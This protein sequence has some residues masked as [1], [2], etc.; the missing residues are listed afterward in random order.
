MEA[1]ELVDAVPQK[2][3]KH[4]SYNQQLKEVHLPSVFNKLQYETEV[5]DN[6]SHFH[7]A[8]DDWRQLSMAPSFLKFAKKADPLSGSMALL[9]HHWQDI[10][11]LWGEAMDSSD[12]EGLRALLDLLQK[13]T[14]DLRTTIAPAYNDLL[15][16]LL[17]LLAKS[18]SPTALTS[19]LET[20][21]CLFRYLLV[22][23]IHLDLLEHTWTRIKATLPK[24]LPEIQR[25]MAEVWGSVLRKLKST[26]R[27]KAVT[28]LA[29]EAEVVD[30]ASAWVLVYA[31]K[32]VS[33]TLHTATP[34]I[35]SPIL[36][37]HLDAEDPEPTFKLLR[38]SLTAL[39]HHVKTAD[40]FADLGNLLIQQLKTVSQG[41]NV[42]HLKRTLAVV[43][44]ISSVRQGSR[45]TENQKTTLVSHLETL[46]ITSDLHPSL[47]PFVTSIYAATDMSHWIGPGLKFLQRSWGII[48]RREND[49]DDATCIQFSLKLHG[50]L[51]ELGWG[52]W[53]MV[54]LPLVLK[55]TV[56]PNLLESEPS[57]LLA[58]CASLRR[59]KKISPNEVDFVW[60][61]KIEKCALARLEVLK[62]QTGEAVDTEINDIFTLSPFFSEAVIPALI[63][64][65][66]FN[67]QKSADPATDTPRA[68]VIEGAV[69]ALSRRPAKEWT[70]KVPL[71]AWSKQ[72]IERWSWSHH[73]IGSMVVL[74]E[75]ITSNVEQ[76]PFDSAYP[77]LQSALLSYSRPLRLS[78]LRFL[79]SKLVNVPE[80]AGEV[81]KRCLQGEEATVDLQGVRERVL[82]IG[83][84]GQ[85]VGDRQGADVCARWL[86]AQLKVNLR[87]LWSPAIAAIGSLAQRFGDL[88]W[89]LLFAELRS[90]TSSDSSERKVS[91]GGVSDAEQMSDEDVDPWEEERSWRD[92]SAHKLRVVSAQWEDEAHGVKEYIKSHQ[93]KERFDAATYEFQLLSGLGECSSLVEKYNRE[94]IPYF[95]GLLTP[96]FDATTNANIQLSDIQISKQKLISW[97]TLFSKFANPKALYATST[98]K[99][100]YVLF[101]SHPYR[102]LQRI[103]L[104]CLLTY[105]SPHLTSHEDKFR[106]LLDD[107]RWRDELTTLE[108]V[109]LEHRER[110]EVV[111]VLTRLLFG[112]M[113]EKKGRTRGTDRRAA[114]LTALAN[115]TDEELGLLVDLM[116]QPLGM[117][118]NSHSSAAESGFE[119]GTFGGEV[120][121][122][123]MVGY[124]MLLGDLMRLLGSRLVN[125]WPAL[126]GSTIDLVNYAQSKIQELAPAGQQSAEEAPENEDEVEDE[127]V[128]EA[129]HVDSASS[130]TN[131]R[132]L[133][134]IRQ[135]GLKRFADFF[136]VP[137]SFPFDP[138][139]PSAF[140]SFISPRLAHLA[141]ENTQAPSALLDLFQV[142]SREHAQVF[143]LV[144]Y[145]NRLLPSLYNCLVATNVKPAVV[146]RVFD[147]VEK[148]LG[149][150]EEDPEVTTRVLEPHVDLLLTN[151][152]KLVEYAK[153]TAPPPKASS[154]PSVLSL[155][156]TTPLGQR[157]LT[158]LS[159]LA[160]YST[161]PS[162]AITLLNLFLPVFRKPNKQ[163]PE[164]VKS[165]ILIIIRNMMRLVPDLKSLESPLWRRVFDTL[166]H[167][168]LTLKTRV[169][170]TQLVEAFTQLGS[171]ANEQGQGWLLA[172]AQQLASLNAYSVKRLDEPDFD[173][174]LAA[175]SSFND[176]ASQSTSLA[177]LAWI[178][179]LQQAFFDIQDGEELAVRAAAAHTLRRFV[180]VVA[181]SA[182]IAEAIPGGSAEATTYNTVFLSVYLSG[183]R[184]LVSAP[185]HVHSP[186]LE[187]SLS[188]KADLLGVLSYT[189][190]QSPETIS[191]TIAALR[192]LL[193]GGDEEANFFN[194]VLHIQVHRRT[195]A[196]RRLG[197]RADREGFQTAGKEHEAGVVR[198]WLIPIVC[199]FIGNGGGFKT[200]NSAQKQDQQ[201]HLTTNEAIHAMGKLAR[202]LPWAPYYALVQR[203]L[204]LAKARTEWEK[205]YV[206]TIVSVLE[207]FTFVVSDGEEKVEA[208]AMDVDGQESPTAA[209][210]VAEGADA[211]AEEQEEAAVEEGELHIPEAKP[212]APVPRRQPKILTSL[213]S[214]LLPALLTY[215]SPP[216]HRFEEDQTPLTVRL[217]I[218]VAIARLTLYLPVS[219]PQDIDR[220]KTE[221]RR[222]ATELSHMMRSRS[223]EVR[224]S[225]REVLGRIAMLVLRVG[226]EEK[227]VPAAATGED[228]GFDRVQYL[229][230]VVEEL[231]TALVRGPQVHVLACTVQSIVTKVTL[232]VEEANRMEKN[233]EEGVDE[234][235]KTADDDSTIPID[236]TKRSPILLDNI[237]HLICDIASRILFGDVAVSEGQDGAPGPPNHASAA[238]REPRKS[239][240]A[241][242]TLFALAAQFTSP[243]RLPDLFKDVRSVMKTTSNMKVLNMVDEVLRRVSGGLE[244]N[245]GVEL[246]KQEADATTP[247]DGDWLLTVISGLITGNIAFLKERP[248]PLKAK[249]KKKR[250]D[251]SDKP[252]DHIVQTKRVVKQEVD[253][254]AHNS[255]RFIVLGLD[256]FNSAMRR[257]RFMSASDAAYRQIDLL[258]PAIGNTLYSASTPVLLAALKSVAL[259]VTRFATKLPGMRRALPVYV[260]QVISI[261]RTS[262][263]GGGSMGG[264][265]GDLLQSALRTLGVM[266]RDGPKTMTG[267]DGTVSPGVEIQEKDLSFL[268]ELVTPDLEDPDKQN[269]TFTLLRA[270]VSRRFIVPEMYDIMEDRVAPLLVQSQSGVV[271]EQARALLLQFMLDYP[272]G[273]GRLQKTLAFLLRNA[274]TYVHESGRV[275][276]LELLGAILS[277]FQVGLIKEYGEMVFVTLVMVI[278]NDDSAK[279]KEM[280]AALL[281]TLYGRFDP[282]ARKT[283][284]RSWLRKWVKAGTQTTEG[285]KKKL[286]W[287]ALQVWGIVVDAA[288]KD[289]EETVQ[290]WCKDTIED[291]TLALHQ[292]KSHFDSLAQS[293]D[294]D[295]MDVDGPSKPSNELEW[296][297]AYYSLTALSKVLRAVPSYARCDP[298]DKGKGIPVPWN[299]VTAHLLFPHAWVR[300]AAS[301]A[302]GV[303]FNAHPIASVAAILQSSTFEPG[304]PFAPGGLRDTASK[305]C[306]QLKSEHLD[307]ALGLQVVKNLVWI[308]RY[309]SSED[310]DS[311]QSAEIEVE[312]EAED[313]EAG[314]A[315]LEQGP[316]G[317]D[318]LPWLFSKLSYQV[319][320]ALIRR[321]GRQGRNNPNWTQQPLAVVRW[322]AAMV[323]YLEPKRL[324]Q[325][326]THILSPLYRI[327][328]EDTIRD[329]QL[330]ELKTTAIELRELVQQKVGG[331]TFSLVYNTI[332][333]RILDTRRD[334]RTKRVMLATHHP[335]QAQRRKE[336][337]LKLKKD[338]KKRRDHSFIDARGGK[339][340]RKE[341]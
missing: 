237:L 200:T 308:G 233:S 30:D 104:T 276:I 324:E 6:D 175:Y 151:L 181:S 185:L 74:S 105:K 270:I 87:P 118:R 42:Q 149:H 239:T 217:P 292:S 26:A 334:R 128:E 164:K 248:E 16:R 61:T 183:L 232:G 205:V 77:N 48:E 289:Q 216:S 135:L 134:T 92:P 319:R 273:K 197:E 267:S 145:D 191:P 231:A 193:E 121:D 238:F 207:N 235:S 291:V 59:L 18:I 124:L 125:Y 337:K 32:S 13:F 22:P 325:F 333:Q 28:L 53:K 119:F 262:G 27:V 328:E 317:L 107:T 288:V 222:L 14:H 215:L 313:D 58:F 259:L 220:K 98:L 326:L 8:L 170:R 299:L 312:S 88:V 40:Q 255:F 113:L 123:Q 36:A 240:N 280:A 19:L 95:L 21:N 146:D 330:E 12:D 5:A 316:A 144:Q 286:A 274:T 327:I 283:F 126:L 208:D 203:Y 41:T 187:S 226:E 298:S 304:H 35:F 338:S 263:G 249:N 310:D 1:E 150:A 46:P 188:V 256:L 83:R 224:D 116:L 271:R 279:C 132:T 23:S 341:A 108:L 44:V 129:A 269:V 120:G 111:D 236:T 241:S 243:S 335:E 115:C 7:Q 184:S 301:R 86:I 4:Q 75:S 55:A 206:R 69:Q 67:L 295:S 182:V 265:D 73:V 127:G 165:N 89:Q 160:P 209:A 65:I 230:V 257:G 180:D 71:Q 186:T 228:V 171:I 66:D 204:R 213:K 102:P 110:E 294:E 139:L 307:S 84:V 142:W 10:M 155:S 31:C 166:S 80:G 62:E 147:I 296:Q 109:N 97:F 177:P 212:D 332:R 189:V 154:G 33:Q 320:G 179:L 81:V 52:G 309:W 260:N 253:H 178:P 131:P 148:I 25:A 251:G 103:A 266:I 79:N 311:S 136:R 285:G 225:V 284:V 54:A 37:Y 176:D 210:E 297:L 202:H 282:D 218:A 90:V 223:Q 172:I 321:K 24:C 196:V 198:D 306:D 76:L 43:T 45:L 91:N 190:A 245:A 173:R 242:Y 211:E 130:S 114:V 221:L 244:R 64:L 11:A 163:A 329:D 159:L 167:L 72:A 261:I 281:T 302:L 192:P 161:S 195:R 94:L 331:T 264:T 290:D 339:R 2:R 275:S 15:D 29:A 85:V 277:K 50:S 323:T 63:G 47:L 247:P 272:Q 157:H 314:E 39:I 38:R 20:F 68:W 17:N 318:N 122:G 93:E 82:R 99:S 137:I 153:H 201:Q 51:A 340:R 252:D 322:F 117:D 100:V 9:L 219:S 143:F 78:A 162:Q 158:I 214:K 3:F 106:A 305:L 152:A 174:R 60:R 141:Q 156:L 254:Y 229:R 287:V 336:K 300:T 199:W 227:N 303:L 168:L 315:E 101:L 34:S 169:G 250:R 246:K 258:L 96:S 112:L 57:K 70:T 234:S 278:A 49:A 194:N 293:A 268:L 133:R 138:Y 140:S 56:R